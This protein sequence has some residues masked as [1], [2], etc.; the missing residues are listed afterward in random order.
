MEANT[1]R[2]MWKVVDSQSTSHFQRELVRVVR[3]ETRSAAKRGL[4]GIISKCFSGKRDINDLSSQL[5][6]I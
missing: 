6:N 1:K 4:F 2:K 5:Q 3:G